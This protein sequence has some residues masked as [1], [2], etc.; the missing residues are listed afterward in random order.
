MLGSGHLLPVREQVRQKGEESDV[1]ITYPFDE[2]RTTHEFDACALCL[3]RLPAFSK[4]EY[5]ILRLRF[6]LSRQIYSPLWYRGSTL[7]S[8]LDDELEGGIWSCNFDSL[9][10][11]R[12]SVSAPNRRYN[13]LVSYPQDFDS[14]CKWHFLM[15]VY[16]FASFESLLPLPRSEFSLG[17]SWPRLDF[18]YVGRF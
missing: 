8:G 7:H 3:F 14:I 2:L 12:H 6:G 9:R 13:G 16:V 10:V 5:T 15:F 17:R 4:S 18:T 11:S 1:P